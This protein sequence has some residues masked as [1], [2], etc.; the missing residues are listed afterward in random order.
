MTGSCKG[1]IEVICYGLLLTVFIFGLCPVLYLIVNGLRLYSFIITSFISCIF[2]VVL[3]IIDYNNKMNALLNDHNTY[4][5]VS[6]SPF[7]R[8]EREL[9]NKLS[10]LKNQ[11]KICDSTYRKLTLYHPP[12]V[13]Q[14]SITKKATHS[15]QLFY[16]LVQR[17]IT[18]RSF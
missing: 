12:S 17:S 2:Y 16:P 3:D 13:A 4:E 14:L 7:C 11:Q 15:D 18:P 6:K 9:K 10:T 1:P 8:N 5:L